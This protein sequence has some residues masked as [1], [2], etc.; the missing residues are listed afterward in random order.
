[1][2]STPHTT[3]QQH[4][5]TCFHCGGIC[6][7]DA[8]LYQEKNFCCQ[9]CKSVYELLSTCQLDSG[10]YRYAEAP[11]TKQLK[12]PR[13]EE[14]AY[15]DEDSIQD[16]L[17]AFRSATLC[18]ISLHLPAIHCASCI[19]LIEHFHKL[20]PGV[21][22]SR[23]NF[24]RRHAD[25][26]YDPRV[27]SLRRIAEQLA[28]IGY[29]PELKLEATTRKQTSSYTRRLVMQMG[30]AGFCFGN[31]MMLSLPEYLGGGNPGAAYRMFFGYINFAL[32]LPVLLFS[33]RDYMSSGWQAVWRRN[34]NMDVPISLG[35]IALFVRSSYEI[36]VEGGGGYM[37]SLA[38]LIFFLLIGKWIQQ[39]TY[40]SLS[41]ER[42]YRS[43]FP[44]AVQRLTPNG[45]VAT[46]IDT[47]RTGD[48]YRVRS[49]E[50]IPVD[51]VLVEGSGAIDYSFVSGEKDPVMASP[52]DK[53]YAGGRQTGPG[54]VLEATKTV[55]Q[56]YL[57]G[58]WNASGGREE[59]HRLEAFA[60]RV[61]MRFT[62]VVLTISVL[63][64]AYW[65][66]YDPPVAWNAVSAV[67]IVA[68][69]CALAL[70]FPFAFANAMRLLGRKGLYLKNA[71]ALGRMAEVNHIA[72]DKTGT[73]THAGASQIAWNGS[74]PPT[75]ALHAAYS[76][77]LQSG[78]PLSRMLAGWLSPNAEQLPVTR[79]TEQVG[80][81]IEAVVQ[82]RVYRLGSTAFVH[83]P[84]RG[85]NA[86]ASEIHLGCDGQWLGCF[87]VNKT[88]RSGLSTLVAQLRARYK[89]YMLSGDNDSERTNIERIFGQREN[90]Y[91]NQSP[92][93]KVEFMRALRSQGAIAAM[94]GDGLNDAGALRESD[95]GISVADDV[96][97][98]AP[99]SDAILSSKHFGQL[100]QFFA[101]ARGTLTV[102]RLSFVLSFAYN[103]V[104]VFF[105]VRGML[106]PVI[107]A[108]LMPVSSITV[109]GFVTL[110]TT[111]LYRKHLSKTDKSQLAK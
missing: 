22:S 26:D 8:L 60:D 83:A 92:F 18:K 39:R 44:I 80:K 27:V 16:K 88:Y 14:Y 35:I 25:F 84:Q 10:Y 85:E 81:G 11:G 71:F 75:E 1:M 79:F 111:W 97:R 89:L 102:V 96:F 109:V 103:A 2:Q 110:G 41:F 46:G 15:L 12:A 9:G 86:L 73:L 61:G 48:R 63:A 91:F 62:Y 72:F 43:Y 23:V 66:V 3:I 99:A 106:E 36:F 20:V 68:C 76:M 77:A 38:A 104:G 30:V 101:F 107:A 78:H 42:D 37:D 32:A 34:I 17:L 7:S 28:A 4:K 49:S 69:P 93:D 50:L 74:T 67:L 40:D 21:V 105:A 90:I 64:A 54:V 57:T 55:D 87:V 98:F 65:M 95:L 56:S 47:L 19:W 29:A 24:T 45:E 58:L 13:R 82:G 94:I 51:S 31:I 52:G 6:E 59:V 70:S 5:A 100:P 53:V 108:V 33:A